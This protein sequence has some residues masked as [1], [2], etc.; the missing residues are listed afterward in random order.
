[1]VPSISANGGNI[2][3]LNSNALEIIYRTMDKKSIMNIRKSYQLLRLL[4]KYGVFAMASL[5]TIHCGL[6]VSGHDLLC[7]HV[8]MCVFLFILGVCLSNLF[9]LC[10]MHKLCVLYVCMVVSCIVLNRHQIFHLLGLD[11]GGARITM[12]TLGVIIV[13]GS[14]WKIQEK[15]C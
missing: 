6:L 1:M 2:A 10:L 14:L 9:N 4:V 15:S 12:Y 13:G 8:L 11:L 5:C 3:F 7:I